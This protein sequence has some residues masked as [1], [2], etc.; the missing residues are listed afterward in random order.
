MD[1]PIV[2]VGA[3]CRLAGEATSVDALWHKMNKSKSGHGP[4]P[5]DRWNADAWYHPDPDR[6]GAITAKSGFFLDQDVGS[7]DA[8]FFSVTA[9]EAAGMD[10]AKRMLLEV[11]YEAFENAGMPLDK[12]AG[13]R[14]G[15][16]VG[17]MTSDYEDMSTHDIYD[18]AHNTAAGVSEAMTANRVSWFFDLRGP[19][20]TIDT[21]CSS[22]LY[23]LHLA[24]QSLQLGETD[25]AI[26]A[27]VNLI[28]YPN[29][30]SQLT[31]M[32]MLSPDGTSHSYDSR[33][34]G[35]GRGEGVG[36][37]VVKRLSDALRDGD[38]IRAVVRGSAVNTDGKTPSVTMPSSTAQTELIRTAYE[39]A[40]LGLEDTAYVEMHGTGTPVG[41]PI[42]FSAIAA[43]FGAV[44]TAENPTYVGSIKPAV[45]HTEGCAGLAGVLRAIVSL[46]KGTLLPTVGVE[47][48]N[49]KLKFKDVNLAL[50]PRCMPWPRSGARRVSVN[51]FGFGGANAHVILDDAYHYM[52][53]RSI[54]GLHDTDIPTKTQTNDS[55]I[56]GRSVPGE[57]KAKQVF[58]FSARDQPGLKRIAKS[59]QP[60]VET[61]SG[62]SQDKDAKLTYL[63]NLAYTLSTRRSLFD[64]RSFVVADSLEELC[65]QLSKSMLPQ[66]RRSSKLNGNVFVFT[67]QGAQW[68]GMGKE[69]LPHYPVFAESIT[70]S[71]AILSSLGCKFDLLEEMN[72]THGSSLDSADYSQ[73]IC[74]AV[75]VGIVDLLRS[76]G[77]TP[78]A[79]IGHSSG[80]IAAAYGAGIISHDDAIKVAYWRGIYSLQVTNGPRKG[81]MLAAG[82][83]PEEASHFLQALPETS[84]AVTA[85]INSPESV[86]LSGDADAITILNKKISSKKKFARKL[87]VATAYHSPHMRDVADECLG[88]M[89]KSGLS[90]PKETKVL[91][92]SSVTGDL[93]DHNELGASYWIRNMCQ[94]VLFSGAMKNLLT[95]TP[96]KR[97]GSRLVPYKWTSVVEV[98]PHSALKAPVTQVM[99]SLDPKLPKDIPCFSVLVR[100]EHAVSSALKAAATLWAL[101]NPIALDKVNLDAESKN[102]P[103]PQPLTD[104]PPYQ[105]NH[106][107]QYWHETSG[108]RS[109]RLKTQPRTDVLGV[110]VNNQNQFE[111]QWTNHLRISENPW[112]AD[113]AITGTVLYPGAGMLIMVLEAAQQMATEKKDRV[114]RGIEFR[115]VHFDRGLVVPVGEES[116]ETRLS[117]RLPEEQDE[118]L[119]GFGV[120]S[121][122]GG[123]SSWVKHCFG[124]FIIQYENL[125][126][127]QWNHSKEEFDRLKTSSTKEVEVGK[128]YKDL[129]GIGMEYGDMFQNLTS[130][131]ATEDGSACYGSVK[132]PDT[133]SVMPSEYE[134]PHVIHPATL[135][136]I[137]HLMV[138]AVSDSGS[139]KE[140]AVP[141]RLK[142][143]FISSDLPRDPGSLFWG[144]SHRLDQ[145]PGSEG[146]LGADLVVSDESWNAP[147]II[148]DGLSMRQVTGAGSGALDPTPDDGGLMKRC[149]VL[150]WKLDSESFVHASSAETSPPSQS[151]SMTRLEDWLEVECHKKAGLTLLIDGNTVT[152]G[153]VVHQLEP[154]ISGKG[155]YREMTKVT[156]VG[157]SDEV[158][159]HWR[160]TFANK[161]HVSA[162]DLQLRG[163]DD[164]KGHV[165][166]VL[167][168][169]ADDAHSPEATASS[170]AQHLRPRGRVLIL[171][172]VN[173]V[174]HGQTNGASEH[175]FNTRCLP[176]GDGQLLTVAAPISDSSFTPQTIRLLL[177]DSFLDPQVQALA[178]QLEQRL[179][180]DSHT[181]R[182]SYTADMVND[183]SG[184]EHII[185][186]LD[187]GSAGGFVSNWTA[188]DFGSFRT[189]LGS[190]KQI[191]WLSR[192]GQMLLPDQ[193]G[194][195]TA[196][197]TGFLRVLRN[198][199]PQLTI[200][201]L[202]LSTSSDVSVID[203]VLRLWTSTIEQE[204]DDSRD[205]ELAELDDVAK[206]PA[207]VPLDGA[208]TTILVYLTAHYILDRVVSLEE[209]ETILISDVLTPLGQALASLSRSKG[210]VVL[211]TATDVAEKKLII[212][213]VG[214]SEDSIANLTKNS[215]ASF[216]QSRPG[217][218]NIDVMVASAAQR[219]VYRDIFD[220]VADF[221][222]VAVILDSNEE[223]IPPRKLGSGNISYATVSPLGVTKGKGSKNI[224]AQLIKRIPE[225]FDSGAAL[226]Y[227]SPIIF[228]TSQLR[229]AVEVASKSTDRAIV[230]VEFADT[231]LV[232]V[233]PPSRPK[234]QLPAEA[235]YVLAGGLGSLGLRIARLMVEHGAKHIVLLSRSGK[236]PKWDGQVSDITGL[237]A[238]VQIIKCDVTKKEEVE[239][240]MASL[241]KDGRKVHGV[242][243]CAMVLQD[244]I[245]SN[246]THKQWQTAFNPKVAGTWHLHN[247]LLNA[248]LDFFIMMSSVVSVIGN[249]SQANYASANSFMDAFA[250]YRREVLN[251]PA[252][253]LNVG[254]VRDSDHE[255]DGTG[256]E[257]YLERFEHMASV[258]TTLDEMDIGLLECMRPGNTTPP[259]VVFGM[260]DGLRRE[261]QWTRDLKFGHRIARAVLSTALGAANEDAGPDVQAAMAS[262]TSVA[263]AATVVAD[264][265]KA[266]LAPGLG[267]AVGDIGDDKPLY[268]V[269]VDS[270]K[271]VEVRNQVFRELKSDISVFEILSAR[272]LGELSGII[273]M[274]SQLLSAEAKAAGLQGEA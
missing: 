259:Q 18:L 233:R 188:S 174:E 205:L 256:M 175:S 45:G 37:V 79:V 227:P 169:Q 118:V 142:R 43:T 161:S 91:M 257:H 92:F 10:P 81:A 147:K 232:P 148:V 94:P 130:L 211:A 42:E 269:G 95:Y 76:W 242:V 197:T 143:M 34:N 254:L 2:I 90:E 246:M 69:L 198:E 136:A 140:A 243:Q 265:L 244:S 260:S 173:G 201:H 39:R 26:V 36:A 62:T 226:L 258:S 177:P 236:N 150:K 85:C 245:F 155:L 1:D 40:G 253:S 109:E 97:H 230:A 181:V 189:L 89:K 163:T 129:Y 156:V 32:H 71:A 249:V 19:S 153:D 144:Y 66:F 196:A 59:L 73:P 154:V 157:D 206:V 108:T 182:K 30:M 3:A 172:Q 128:L 125:S 209:S 41:D 53:Q 117:I 24:I 54:E 121:N 5:S 192:G 158:L 248:P 56:A 103:K 31:A 98:G 179:L 251:L 74:A 190:A 12:V 131:Q 22:S 194:L 134:F 107:K 135:D 48:V 122:P 141:Y 270:F 238:E 264:A 219:S 111:P 8:P 86:T 273:A 72:R 112:I 4:V 240:A 63:H 52:K 16:Y 149:T 88:A 23:A 252:V 215:V 204:D 11:T 57:Q 199:N 116:I 207:G 229:E 231:A 38:V 213:Q 262:A 165:D 168:G 58:V 224:I 176:L 208:A 132:I 120:F 261:D 70:R 35:Y 180:E 202:D 210:A 212:E 228:P 83:S 247:S 113:H 187:L 123:S 104:L 96:N 133:K 170:W 239:D 51:S 126:T 28:L 186:L 21:A 216:L 7:F 274:G 14:T 217:E 55:T 203:T 160:E 195:E 268:E 47:T 124:N 225:I 61:L 20:L 221:G 27:G 13:T 235:S 93:I 44:S 17:C 65:T 84:V 119:H 99:E 68:A 145:G 105:W 200:T 166:I 110:P 60:H 138:F 218:N 64:H 50:P 271:A 214:L 167:V 159:D 146:Q 106:D 185:S 266:L 152:T 29:A 191:F 82:I 137:F 6:K 100:N 78:K 183:F 255:I 49:P 267:V 237:G 263:E 171:S 162:I 272:P 223:H 114:F 15:V 33:A 222:R 77:I 151:K 46:E 80:E 102:K 127:E 220:F 193:A 139:W 241:G 67:G 115:D 75:Q 87:R 164:V 250:H 234:L 178:E 9:K 101:G 184:D 25:S